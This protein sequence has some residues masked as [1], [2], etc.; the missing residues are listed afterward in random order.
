MPYA[1]LLNA[2]QMPSTS[3]PDSFNLVHIMGLSQATTAAG[4]SLAIWDGRDQI[5]LLL[6]TKI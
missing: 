5:T 2:E 3:R 6:R 4:K 1:A